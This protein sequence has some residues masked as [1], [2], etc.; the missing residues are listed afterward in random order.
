MNFTF[1]QVCPLGLAE[2]AQANVAMLLE[3]SPD[4]GT[5]ACNHLPVPRRDLGLA[6]GEG[7]REIGRVRAERGPEEEDGIVPRGHPS[8]KGDK[9]T[10]PDRDPPDEAVVPVHLGAQAVS[11]PR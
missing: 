5:T 11:L 2:D 10:A 8:R 1:H 4:P 6:D 7:L 3:N 9:D